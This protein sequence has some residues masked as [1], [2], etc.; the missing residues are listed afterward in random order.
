MIEKV[1]EYNQ[2]FVTLMNIINRAKLNPP[3]E[4]HKH[5]I[6]PRCWFKMNGLNVDGRTWQLVDG[7]RVWLPN[8]VK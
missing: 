3:K 2:H 8:E 1:F 7:K 6:I 5:H 4:G